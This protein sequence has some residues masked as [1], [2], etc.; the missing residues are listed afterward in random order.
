MQGV[1]FAW[2]VHAAQEQWSTRAD[3]KAAAVFTVEGALIA[4][5]VAAFSNSTFAGSISGWRLLMLGLGTLSSAVAVVTAFLV[6]IPQLG[7]RRRMSQE[8]HFIY[9]GHLC[10]WEATGLA[11]RLIALSV[12]EQIA[13]LSAQLTRLG[14][15]NWR[16]YQLLRA[17]VIAALLGSLLLLV[18][19]PWPRM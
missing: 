15:G 19:F 17:A 1:E 16:K 9:F 2:K 4:A 10:S 13:Q 3:T 6:V 12:P 7:W 5:V 11:E 14:V 8:S 18:A